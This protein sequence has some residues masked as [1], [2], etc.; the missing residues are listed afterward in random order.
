VAAPF[1]TLSEDLGGFVER[2]VPGAFARS[3]RERDVKAFVHHDLRLMLGRVGNGTLRLD[4]AA[5][6]LRFEVDPPKTDTGF[7]TS[8]LVRRRDLIGM[9]FGFRVPEGGDAWAR[10]GGRVVRTLLEVEL[11]E[12]SAVVFPAYPRTSI[13]VVPRDGSRRS[14]IAAIEANLG[15]ERR[16]RTLQLEMEAA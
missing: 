4:E 12:I 2:I 16:L 11:V 5:E 14:R 13:E 3:L 9:S 10:E 1:N 8:R 15:R 7:D 6:G